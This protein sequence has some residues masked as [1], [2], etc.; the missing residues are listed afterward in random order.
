MLINDLN[1]LPDM[2]KDGVRGLLLLL[3]NKDGETGNTQRKCIKKISRNKEEWTEIIHQFNGLRQ[4]A[5]PRHRIYASV[6]PRNMDKAVHEFKSRALGVDYGSIQERDWFYVDLENRFFSCLMNPN[7]RT[8]S[9]FL[10][11]CDTISEYEHARTVIPNELVLFDYQTKNGRHII[12]RPCNPNLF[13]SI[14]FKKDE[15]LFIG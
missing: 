1:Q 3:R 5:Y 15:L 13:P 2:F 10:V 14:E 8:E 6:N 7:C 11:D 9:N 4:S 12:T